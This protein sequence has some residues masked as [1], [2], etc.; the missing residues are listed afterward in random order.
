LKYSE[1]TL[2]TVASSLHNRR[3]SAIRT[4]FYN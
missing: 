3:Y 2:E 4:E 1:K